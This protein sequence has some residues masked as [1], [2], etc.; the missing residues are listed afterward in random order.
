MPCDD[1]KG[2]LPGRGVPPG[3]GACE[4]GVAGVGAPGPGL[5]APGAAGAA[6]ASAAGAAGAA[7]ARRGAFAAGA[8][9]AAR[10]A[11]AGAAGAAGAAAGR[12]G[13]G[14]TAGPGL[15]ADA[16]GFAPPAAGAAAGLAAGAASADL[17][18]AVGLERSAKLSR[19]GGLDGGRGA[20]DVFAELLQLLERDLAVDAELGSDLV[21]AWFGVCH[22]S[23]VWGPPRQG[24]PLVADGSHFEPFTLFP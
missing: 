19:H 14:L 9:A 23:P 4:A 18:C 12:A 13:P 15:A 22:N 21:H 10:A 17:L 1:A 7:G 5:G 11:G 2:L 8:G 16:P 6:G 20:L 24:R 3:R